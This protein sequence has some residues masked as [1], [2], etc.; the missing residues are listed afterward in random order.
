MY[1]MAYKYRVYPTKEQRRFLAQ[2]FGCARY[3]WNWAL[4][5]RTDAYHDE[6]ESLGFADMCRKLTQ[7]KR[8]EEHEWL[9]DPSSVVLQQSL[10]NQEQAFT[11]FFDGRAGYPSFKRKH[12]T[13]TARHTKAAFSFDADTRTLSLAKMPGTLKVNW[14][15]DLRGE[16]TAVTISKDPAG[17]YHVSIE[18]KAPVED[19]AKTG[20]AVGVD[21]G[22]ESY[23][24]FRQARRWAILAF[25]K[26]PTAACA[27]SRRTFLERRG[28][29]TTGSARRSGWR[30]HM[31]K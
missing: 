16:P 4:E 25:S 18:F 29:R 7:L 26:M 10:R 27:K 8:N 1:H 24:T 9:K 21:V 28:A 11:N 14:S 3:V 15:R 12:G 20:K 6:G 23:I 22:L 5:H 30:R 31:R 17:R 13:Q 2:T 19:K